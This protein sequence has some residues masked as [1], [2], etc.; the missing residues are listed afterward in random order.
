MMKKIRIRKKKSGAP[1]Q[2]RKVRG[3]K[4]GPILTVIGCVLAVV[5]CLIAFIRFVPGLAEKAANAP[6]DLSW[7][8]YYTPEPENGESGP[9]PVPT[10]DPASGHA[11]Y[12]ADLSVSQH[13]VLL[14]EYQF[15]ADVRFREGEVWCAVGPYDSKTGLAAFSAA[16]C[17]QPDA[18][19]KTYIP[20]SIYYNSM[21]FPIGNEDWVV[22]ADVQNAGGGRM[23]C[24]NRHT[25]EQRTLKVVH[26]G[27]PIPF[28]WHDCAF[29]VERT[30]TDTFKL[31]GC[32]L[33]T[34]ESVTLDVFSSKGGVS[35]PFL[36]GDTLMYNGE[37]GVLYALDLRTGEKKVLVS[38]SVAHDAKTNGTMLA[39]M[40]GFH[41]LESEL[42]YVDENGV[43]H[44]AAKGVTDFA[45]GDDFI[46]YGDLQKCYVY[47]PSDGVTFCLTRAKET[48]LFVGA[49]G[50]RVFWI[51]T[52][53]HDKDVLEF[54]HVDHPEK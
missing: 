38:G 14:N 12:S 33:A 30:G 3:T 2:I 4:A 34:G 25:G 19:T 17:I 37:D 39:Y 31:F 7:L 32:D 18:G 27:V 21:R 47:F 40:T 22:F 45:L 44:V 51:D 42:I 43:E 29:W 13:E 35:R 10:K 41:D 8:G 24:I 23:C 36:R 11:L 50:D 26:I 9:T 1:K 28:I 53:W 20:A 48:S 49:D 46:A 15:L 54:M 6:V 52:S 16:A 5:L